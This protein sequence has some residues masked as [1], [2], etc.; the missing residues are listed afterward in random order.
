MW[1]ASAA[2]TRLHHYMLYII[3]DNISL[4]NSSPSQDINYRLL[5]G[6]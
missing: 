3:V 1:S 4:A 5:I 6:V 2:A